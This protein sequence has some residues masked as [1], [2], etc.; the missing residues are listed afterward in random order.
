MP[1]LCIAK[2]K[3]FNYQTFSISIFRICIINQFYRDYS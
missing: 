2:Q 1:Y 3:V